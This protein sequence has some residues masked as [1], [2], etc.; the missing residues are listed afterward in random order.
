R[1]RVLNLGH[2]LGHAVEAL[3]GGEL[4]H[5]EAVAIGLV[6]AARLAESDGIAEPGLADRVEA[7][8]ERIGLPTRVPAG[9]EAEDLIGRIRHD[10]KRAGGVV[11]MVLPVAPGEVEV[12]P[13]G[14]ATVE[15]WVA[16]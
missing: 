5:G 14:G 11:H 6:A 4:L 1:R 7:A 9:M 2:T 10:K 8:L 16:S 15:R 13:V 12:R 3:A